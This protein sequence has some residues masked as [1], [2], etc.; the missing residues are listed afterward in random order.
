MRAE[1]GR[2][3]DAQRRVVLDHHDGEGSEPVPVI[4]GSFGE[5]DDERG[6]ASGSGLHLDGA[7]VGVDEGARDGE[8]EP[9]AAA[10]GGADEAHELFEHLL[11]VL[12]R[13]ARPVVDHPDLAGAAVVETHDDRDLGAG[14]R[15]AER[16]LEQHHD[17]QLDHLRIERD[18][19][20]VALDG[21]ADAI[22]SGEMAEPSH[23]APGELA[24][25][26]GFEARVERA[27][28]D[29]AQLEHLGDEPFEPLRFFA[30]GEEQ[31]GAGR[32]VELRGRVFQRR[33]RRLDRR[34]RR[35]E[36]VGHGGE[37]RRPALVDRGGEAGFEGG[38]FLVF[39]P[40]AERV[41]PGDGQTR[42]D[43]RER[44][45]DGGDDLV[46]LREGE[47]LVLG[48]EPVDEG[49]VR[50]IAPTAPAQ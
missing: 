24:D 21:E 30:G 49:E 39:G 42:D 33:H 9:G 18:D 25:V 13:D 48:D 6:A 31:Q 41:H 19:H 20:H 10:V 27:R 36:V 45:G 50:R 15:E 12:R 14:G 22:T 16:V 2:E 32:V 5:R 7:V 47:R 29:P 4:D 34:E 44:E 23:R 28:M 35:A 37:E 1:A 43:G 8:A 40:L 38:A 3:R 26:D 17:D 11:A 46:G